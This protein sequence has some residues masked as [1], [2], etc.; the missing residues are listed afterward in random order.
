[1]QMDAGLDTGPMLLGE[2]IAIAADMNAQQLHDALCAMGGRLIVEALAG[3][4]EGRI[5]PENQPED[6]VTYA[7]KI[8]KA[9]TRIDWRR[10]ADELA[11]SVRA[12]YPM[13]WFERDTQR[14]RVLRAVAEDAAGMPGSALDDALL[15]A[16]GE[17]AL[18]L[19][20]VQP[21]GKAAMAADAYLRGNPLKAGTILD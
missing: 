21:A 14:V 13:T 8:D 7:K 3:V 17:G 9:E 1:M 18:R 2:T 6:G 5:V 12:L 11:R 20:E 4:V 16:C 10:P 15:V 19:V